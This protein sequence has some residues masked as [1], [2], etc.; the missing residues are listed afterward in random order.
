[1]AHA[2]QSKGDR[3]PFEWFKR[4][5]SPQAWRDFAETVEALPIKRR[6]KRN[7]LLED[8]AALASELSRAQSQRHPL[9]LPRAR[10]GSQ[11]DVSG[12]RAPS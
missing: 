10:R 4:E 11:I 2:N 8:G 12:K 7:F 5:K 6:K 1:M 3:T 9:G